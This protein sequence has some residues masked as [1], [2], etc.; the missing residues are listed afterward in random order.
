MLSNKDIYLTVVVQSNPPDK[1]ISSI[2][3]PV[4]KPVLDESFENGLGDEWLR[5]MANDTYS[6]TISAKYAQEGT[7]SYRMEL[8]KTDSI[9]AEGKRSEITTIEPASFQVW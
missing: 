2:S 6:G 3:F 4:I 9:V 7:H 1:V 8:R 5:E